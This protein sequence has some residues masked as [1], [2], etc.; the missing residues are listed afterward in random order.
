MQEYGTRRGVW[1]AAAGV[2]VLVHAA[3]LAGLEWAKPFSPAAVHAEPPP[4]ELVF[5]PE[6][7][8][9]PAATEDPHFFTELP[10]DRSDQAPE[11]PEALSNVTSRARDAVP[12]GEADALP[13]LTGASDAPEVALVPRQEAS[14]PAPGAE[15]TQGQTPSPSEDADLGRDIASSPAP[16]SAQAQDELSKVILRPG[17]SSDIP[18]EA[19]SNPD[20]NTVLDGEIS[21]NTTAWDYAPWLQRF[22]REFV[23]NWFAP[24]AYDLGLIHGWNVVELEIDRSGKLLRLDVLESDGHPSLVQSSLGAFRSIA[25]YQPLPD[26]FPEEH[27]ILKA[28]LVYPEARHR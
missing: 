23:K 21:L 3:A 18:Q 24:P 28:K 27:L 16:G 1:L 17:G 12:G 26:D 2:A 10:P 8:P 22:R 4:V 6:D 19:M 25:P 20:G 14:S 9:A 13:R 7:S 5:A 15:G 11:H